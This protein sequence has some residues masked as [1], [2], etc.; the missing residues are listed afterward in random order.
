L[1]LSPNEEKTNDS[2]KRGEVSKY[3]EKYLDENI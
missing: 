2:N 1:L 3:N